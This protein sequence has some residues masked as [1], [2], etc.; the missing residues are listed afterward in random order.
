MGLFSQ[1]LEAHPTVEVTI[2]K[3][4]PTPATANFP[5]SDV[6]LK[7]KLAGN[8]SKFYALGVKSISSDCPWQYE[9]A[10]EFESPPAL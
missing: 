3:I 2:L 9:I 4:V 7:M 8:F 1:P 5:F 6:E 10:C